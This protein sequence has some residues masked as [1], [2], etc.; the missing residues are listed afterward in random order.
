M[1]VYIIKRRV[2]N[3]D[4]NIIVTLSKAMADHLVEQFSGSE[5]Y[6]IEEHK[7]IDDIRA[8]II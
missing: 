4:K 8:N 2:D 5:L 1:K 3:S 6:E 7:I